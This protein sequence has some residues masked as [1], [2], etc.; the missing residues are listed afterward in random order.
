[1]SADEAPKIAMFCTGGIRCEKATALLRAEGIENVYHLQGGILNYLEEVPA[2]ESLWEGECFVFDQ[3]VC[4]AHG[5][6]EGSFEICHACRMPVAEEDKSN[7]HYQAGVSCPGCHGTRNS[8]QRERY[9][10]RYRQARLAEKRGEKH[11][12]PSR[13]DG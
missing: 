6:E 4:L 13:D 9:A 12:G 8:I 2:E 7:P 11:I 5:L 3:R 1:L 10:E